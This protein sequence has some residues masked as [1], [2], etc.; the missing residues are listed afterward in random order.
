MTKMRGIFC[1]VLMIFYLSFSAQAETGFQFHRSGK[2]S[3]K[4]K[5]INYNNLII[6]EAKLNGQPMNF[7]LDSG[8]DKTI[9]F[10]IEGDEELIKKN[11]KKILI[12][13][14]SGK[15]KAYAY[16]NK[17][18]RLAIGKLEDK[19]HNI[20]VIF[21]KAFNISDKIGYQIQGIIGYNF[22]KDHI[23]RINYIRDYLKV[24]NTK[25]FSKPLRRYD[26]KTISLYDQKPYIKTKVKQKNTFEEFIFLLDIGSGD[27]IWLKKQPGQKP[28]EKSF[29]DILGY[30]LA[31]VIFGIRSKAKAFN[32]GSQTVMNPKIAY[33]DSSSYQGLRLTPKSGVIGSEIMRRFH[34]YFDY[35]NRKVYFKP[36]SHFHE[37]FNYDM[38]GLILRYD[39]FQTITKFRNIFPRVKVKTDNRGGYNK[40][41]NSEIKI[42]VEKRPILI[43]GAVRPN[44]SAFEA[45]FVEGDEILKINGKDS[46]KYDFEDIAKLLSSKE[47]LK[48]NFDI[49]RNG[50]IYQKSLILKS[51]FLE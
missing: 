40:F 35:K 51:R 14:V 45:G 46:Y 42:D 9:L 3:Y 20:Y 27:A 29:Y 34:W 47:G 43:V 41:K 10:G 38:S 12:K 36:N 50:S 24:Y 17:N 16:K 33:P 49:N 2:R 18:N 22:F 7:L 8:V 21:D 6:F 19:A 4:I 30:G 31:D 1:S 13:G 37:D 5:F 48:I 11:S 26:S 44:S 28:P 25:T 23:V 15:K 39:G 32:L